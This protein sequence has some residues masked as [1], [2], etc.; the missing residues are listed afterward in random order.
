MPSRFILGLWTLVWVSTVSTSLAFGTMQESA[1]ST[2]PRVEIDEAAPPPS[3]AYGFLIRFAD[4][5]CPSCEYHS[6]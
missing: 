6:I 4:S 5:L 2:M 3:W 1:D